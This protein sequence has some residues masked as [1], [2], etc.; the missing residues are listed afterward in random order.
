M[1]SKIIENNNIKI[2][3]L[4]ISDLKFRIKNEGKDISKDDDS[5]TN[6]SVSNNQLD[7]IKVTRSFS[8]DYKNYNLFATV[9]AWLGMDNDEIGKIIKKEQINDSDNDKLIE[10]LLQV[11]P[12]MQDKIT[13]YSG[14]LSTEADNNYM[15]IPHFNEQ[16]SLKDI[17]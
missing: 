11:T 2:I 9:N 1:K 10:V 7:E 5:T 3:K 12:I 13:V 15:V 4:Y 6:F 16:T 8:V 17:E 14:L